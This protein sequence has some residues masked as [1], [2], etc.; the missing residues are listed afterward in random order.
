MSNNSSR[1]VPI[2]EMEM[3]LGKLGY[4]NELKGKNSD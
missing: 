1:P 3:I 4:T 2:H